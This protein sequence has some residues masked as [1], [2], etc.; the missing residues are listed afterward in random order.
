MT[1]QSKTVRRRVVV[2]RKSSSDTV[3]KKPKL[4]DKPPVTKGPRS[5]GRTR[6]GKY[7]VPR[8]WV[9]SHTSS[10]LVKGF[11]LGR[12][13]VIDMH[14]PERA[15]ARGTNPSGY[16]T[17]KEAAKIAKKYRDKYGAWAKV[18]F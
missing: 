2:R 11:R 5:Y 9:Y 15:S 12:H 13:Y 7:I 1:A 4:P 8:F 18:P 3:Y 10:V 6:K 17:E 16:A 14:E